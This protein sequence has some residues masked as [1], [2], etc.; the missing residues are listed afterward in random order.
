MWLGNLNAKVVIVGQDPAG[1][2][3]V[4]ANDP[5]S[6]APGADVGTNVT[7]QQLLAAALIDLSDVYLT[8]AI[9]CIKNGSMNAKPRAAWATNCRPFLRRTLDLVSPVAVVGL[10]GTAWASLCRAYGERVLPLSV[11]ITRPPFRAHS[12]F[13]LVPMFH[14]GP[15]GQASRSLELQT[16]DWRAFGRWLREQPA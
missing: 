9:L 15:L 10:G 14:P 16:G 5:A 6:Y 1:S 2:D 7:L 3:N 13:W 8:N 12:G 4:D 11:A